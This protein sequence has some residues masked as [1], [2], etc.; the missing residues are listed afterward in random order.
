MTLLFHKTDNESVIAYSKNSA[1]FE[2][3]ILVI[4]N[5]DPDN[6]QNGFVYLNAE[7]I[8]S[9]DCSNYKVNDLLYDRSYFWNNTKNYF[10][11]KPDTYIAHL[12]LLSGQFFL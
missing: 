5:L 11:L 1:D 6:Q 12:L 3:V 8:G 9:K 2:N 7:Y 10:E 4:V